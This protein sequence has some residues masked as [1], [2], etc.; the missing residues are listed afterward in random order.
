ML[1][2]PLAQKQLEDILSRLFLEDACDVE[3]VFSGGESE[4]ED[5][6]PDDEDFQP[7]NNEESDSDERN[8][9]EA[10][11]MQER[12][13]NIVEPEHSINLGSINVFFYFRLLDRN[14]LFSLYCL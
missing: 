1:R 11:K 3:I 13:V 5:F 8:E 4:D 14:M 10:D 6:P 2:Q 7:N 9:M 12:D